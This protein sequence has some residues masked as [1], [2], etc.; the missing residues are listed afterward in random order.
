MLVFHDEPKNA[1][2]YAAA[3]TMKRLA[4][5][6]H[7]KRGRL[8]LMKRTKGFEICAG[9]FQGKIR[10]NHFDDVVGG[11][12][13][14]YGFRRNHVGYLFFAR[15]LSEAMSNLLSAGALSKQ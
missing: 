5:R 7:V 13:L 2:A 9:P 6:A 4:L 14:L 15:L 3:K 8:F 10:T 12:D 1:T 11:R